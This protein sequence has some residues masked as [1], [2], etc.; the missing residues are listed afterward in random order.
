M[1]M[2]F[3]IAIGFFPVELSACQVSILAKIALFIHLI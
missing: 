2:E 3:F 1:G